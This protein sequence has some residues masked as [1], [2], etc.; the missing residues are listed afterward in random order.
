M[1]CLRHALALALMLVL[2]AAVANDRVAVP[3]FPARTGVPAELAEGFD[4]SLRAELLAR[5]V[6]AVPAPLITAGIAGSLEVEFTRLVAQLEGSRYALSG[7]LVA[8]PGA[9]AEPFAVNLL[10]VDAVQGRSSDVVSRPLAVA[11]LARV[12][13]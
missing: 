3:S 2:G 11:T 6:S 10:V 12:A 13:A 9:E 5:G 8:R 7:E 1:R 4:A